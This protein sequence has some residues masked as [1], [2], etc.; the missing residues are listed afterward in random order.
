MWA[1]SP[2]ATYTYDPYGNTLGASGSSAAAN[3][4]R[5]SGGYDDGNGLIKFG[6][7]FYDPTL[8]RWTQ[9]DPLAGSINNP[10]SMNRYAYVGGDPCNRLDPSGYASYGEGCVKGAAVDGTIGFLAALPAAWPTGGAGPLIG[11]LVGGASG[12]AESVLFEVAARRLTHEFEIGG[13]GKD[14]IDGLRALVRAL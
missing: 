13:T 10:G 7:R 11:L 1:R 8:G 9:K 12:C 14:W 2:S 3:P 6:T 5:Y 4:W